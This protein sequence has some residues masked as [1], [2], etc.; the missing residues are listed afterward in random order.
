VQAW[1][2]VCLLVVEAR[3]VSDRGAAGTCGRIG[4]IYLVVLFVSWLVWMFCVVCG[5]EAG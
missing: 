4:G 5:G 2:E 3:G 1:V